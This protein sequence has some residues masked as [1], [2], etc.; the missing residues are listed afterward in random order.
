MGST[1]LIRPGK[2][3]PDSDRLFLRQFPGK[4]RFERVSEA[5]WNAPLPHRDIAGYG[6]VIRLEADVRVFNP[7]GQVVHRKWPSRSYIRNFARILR[8]TF[9]QSVQ[10]VDRNGTLWSVPLNVAPGVTSSALIPG[11]FLESNNAGANGQAEQSG[12]AM[13]IGNGVAA[14]VH[15]RNDLVSRFGSVISAR[16]GVRTS[17]LNT[18]TLT[19]EITCGIVNGSAA[20]VNITEIALF[21]FCLPTGEG[22]TDVPFSTLIAYDGI[23]STPLAAGGV[24][25]PR[26]TMDFPM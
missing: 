16:Q 18:S 11:L 9:G 25:A 1:L 6:H 2:A 22:T 14:E 19:L 23:S 17:V 3:K 21:M 24:I 12:A 10:L 4:K 8:N 15:T 5:D 13:G 26:Y 7:T 20:S